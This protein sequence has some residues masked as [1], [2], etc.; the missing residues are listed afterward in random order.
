MLN[1]FAASININPLSGGETI[2]HKERIKKYKIIKFRFASS[3]CINQ[4]CSMEIES[5]HIFQ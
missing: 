3:I 4:K 2:F 1:L 5:L